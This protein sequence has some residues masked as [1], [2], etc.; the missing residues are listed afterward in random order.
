MPAI[1]KRLDEKHLIEPDEGVP[2]LLQTIRIPK[3]F[4]YLTDLLPKPNYAMLK[5]RKIDKQA[6]MQTIAGINKLK[7]NLSNIR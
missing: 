5:T 3:N 1:L 4:H 2:I 7:R 6:Y